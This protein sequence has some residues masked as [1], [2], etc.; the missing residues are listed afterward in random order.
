MKNVISINAW[1]K[2]IFLLALIENKLVVELLNERDNVFSP[3]RFEHDRF[4]ELVLQGASANIDEIGI[5][6]DCISGSY[7][8]EYFNNYFMNSQGKIP[9]IL[10]RLSFIGSNG[11]GALEFLPSDTSSNLTSS[12]LTFSL[13]EFKTQSL[14]IYNNIDVTNLELAKLF[15]KSNSGAGGAKAKAIVDYNP[16]SK[17]LHLSQGFENTPKGYKKSIIKFNGKKGG[18]AEVYNDELK[19]EYLYYLLALKCGVHMSNCYLECDEMGNCYFI[20]ER[21]DVDSKGQKLHLHSLAGLLGHNAESFTMDYGMLFRVGNALSVSKNDKEQ[22]FKTMVFNLVFSNKDDHSRNF[23]F[24]M[25]NDYNWFYSPSY[26]LTYSGSNYAKNWHQLTI[27]NKPSN[28][29]RS[30][31]MINIAKI[32]EIDNPLE[33]ID[34]F[35]DI[36]YQY[37]RELSIEYGIDTKM[38]DMIFKDTKEIDNMFYKGAR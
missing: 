7:G 37:L 20:T 30:L 12:D 21:F 23:S 29:I 15:A 13:L 2:E 1:G 4:A 24:L 11:L 38:V 8:K 6:S 19:L 27:D 22:M 17:M 34:D 9:T 3:I 33:I 26:D 25:D 28:K 18:E 14:D 16:D 31:G 36:K 10:D 5:I 35:I 32:C